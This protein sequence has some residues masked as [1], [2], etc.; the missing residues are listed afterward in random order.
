[1]THVYI[2]L[3]QTREIKISHFYHRL[4]FNFF[5]YKSIDTQN[6]YSLSPAVKTLLNK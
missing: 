2:I 4:E 5:N 6:I 1:M 3:I